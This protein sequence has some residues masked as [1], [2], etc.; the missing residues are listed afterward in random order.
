MNGRRMLQTPR[1]GHACRLSD[2]KVK[3]KKRMVPIRLVPTL[4]LKVHRPAVC[5]KMRMVGLKDQFVGSGNTL[6]P[7]YKEVKNL[8]NFKVLLYRK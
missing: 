3:K 5:D 8:K 4:R 7:F 2:P 1:H 6:F